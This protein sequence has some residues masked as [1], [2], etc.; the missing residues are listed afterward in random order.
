MYSW[1]FK[2]GML[3]VMCMLPSAGENLQLLQCHYLMFQSLIGLP[4]CEGF[5]VIFLVSCFLA[6]TKITAL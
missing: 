6:F 4:V 5:L 3:F 1:F 2:K